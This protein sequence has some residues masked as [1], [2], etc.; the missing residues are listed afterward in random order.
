MKKFTIV[1]VI[2]A[3]ITMSGCLVGSLHPFYKNSDKVYD[4]RLNGNWF[5]DDSCI[6]VIKPNEA[7][8]GFGSSSRKDSTFNIVYYEDT[9]SKAVLVG[10][11]FELNGFKYVDFVP[12]PDEEH[13]MS[14]LTEFHHFPLHTLARID[15]KKDTM[16]L[17]WYGEEWLEN[18]FE[19]NKIRIKHE[20]VA[21]SPDYNRHVLT[22]STEELQKFIL[23]YAN[24][25]ET[26]AQLEA[27]FNDGV[28]TEDHL[29]IKLYPY[30]GEVPNE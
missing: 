16:M 27:A 26:T 20:T 23:K 22:A 5:D 7:S 3:S 13:C 17:F 24:D 28:D 11:L 1:F 14:E 19:E 25:E 2:I 10:T 8:Q 21:V 18:L 4:E 30:D 29:F 9:D 6:W 12:D 15:F